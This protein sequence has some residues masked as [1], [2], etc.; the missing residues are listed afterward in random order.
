L[1]SGAFIV[2]VTDMD[3]NGVVEVTRL[4]RLDF[5]TCEGGEI[6]HTPA[7]PIGGSTPATGGV[8]QQITLHP[9]EIRVLKIEFTTIPV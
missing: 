7:V 3:M 1:P 8:V 5:P 6:R 4:S 2:S 9:M